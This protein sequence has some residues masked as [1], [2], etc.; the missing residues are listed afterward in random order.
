ML[1]CEMFSRLIFYGSPCVPA[2]EKGHEIDHVLK[3]IVWTR[4]QGKENLK[5]RAGLNPTNEGGYANSAALL[6][7]ERGRFFISVDT[8]SRERQ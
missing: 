8:H 5:W 2:Q 7:G 4:T 6:W 3:E 1:D